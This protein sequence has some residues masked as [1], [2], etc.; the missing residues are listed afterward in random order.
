MDSQSNTTRWV[1]TSLIIIIYL[2][3]GFAFLYIGISECPDYPDNNKDDCCSDPNDICGFYLS[4]VCWFIFSGVV[5][6]I[7]LIGMWEGRID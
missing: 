7:I 2:S 4:A 5:F 1:L 6:L 3:L